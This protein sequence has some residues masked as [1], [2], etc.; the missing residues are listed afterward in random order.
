MVIKIDKIPLRK[1][2][3]FFLD[4]RMFPTN[5]FTSICQCDQ[6]N[7]SLQI[8]VSVSMSFTRMVLN[9]LKAMHVGNMIN[10]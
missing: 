2:T 6:E 3:F 5:K 4:L 1:L 9:F 8:V 10:V 7:S